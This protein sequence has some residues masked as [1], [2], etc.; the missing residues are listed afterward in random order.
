M[1]KDIKIAVVYGG[2]STER[3]VSLRSGQAVYEALQE[4]GF[5]EVTLFD[6]HHDN[7]GEL[8]A[9]KPDIAYLALHGRGGEDG[10]IQGVL[11]LAGIPYTGPGVASSAI[12]MNKIYTKNML[13]AA[14]IPTAD[15]IAVHKHAQ[16]NEE[17]C[18]RILQEIGLPAVIKAPCQGSSIGVE[19]VKEAATL[20]KA[21]EDIF[22]YGDQLLAE[23][24][25]SG[26][27]ITI[28]II[29]N[30][31]LTVLPEIE[32]TSERE[33]YDYKAKY[34]SGLCHHIIPAR[35]AEEDRAKAVE[36]AKKVY[37]SFD[38][39]GVSR[40][41]FIIGEDGPIVLEV[42][43]LPGMTAMSLVPDA[44]RTAGIS[45]PE[46]VARI[47]ELGLQKDRA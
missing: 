40:I 4:Y 43:T 47:I 37:R 9:M 7:V 22:R 28:P 33:F 10:C 19:I 38:L 24:F 42:N 41:D 45:F 44:A 13:K 34:T 36:T 21:V 12:C 2:I 16:T 30:D 32:I 23:K 6:L 8:L 3:E 15:Y 26:T 5:Q 29:G 39:C 25:V 18:T 14:G 20:P 35:I 1:K 11:E 46:L 27:E 17:I 31:E